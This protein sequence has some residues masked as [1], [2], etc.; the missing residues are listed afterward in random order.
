MNKRYLIIGIT[1]IV[2]TALLIW[3]PENTNPYTQRM[4]DK[5]NSVVNWIL[6]GAR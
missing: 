4:I 6:R 2:F 3:A 1:L 5:T